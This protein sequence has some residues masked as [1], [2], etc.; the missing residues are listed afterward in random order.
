MLPWLPRRRL[1][2]WRPLVEGLDATSDVDSAPVVLVIAAIVL[3]PVIIVLSVF[4]VEW[5]FVLLLLPLATAASAFAGRPW[6]VVARQRSGLGVHH[7]P[8]ADRLRFA[9]GVRGWHASGRM[10]S[11][12][13]REIAE[14]GAPQS[15]GEPARLSVVRT[16]RRRPPPPGAPAGY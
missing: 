5:L 16:G 14:S 8:R 13:G 11:Q 15:L 12:V 7:V 10:I 6:Q 1:R 9:R 3:L 4:L 2:R